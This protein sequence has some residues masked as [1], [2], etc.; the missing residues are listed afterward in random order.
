M[1]H[2]IFDNVLYIAPHYKY[3]KGGISAVITEY[4]RSIKNFHYLPS[5]TSSNIFL[6]ALSFPFIILI[7]SFRLLVSKKI[8]IV[9]IHGASKGSFYRKFVFFLIAKKFFSKKVVYHIHGAGYHLFYG[10]ASPFIKKRVRRIIN[11]SDCLIVLSA[12]WKDFFENEFNPPHI[13]IVPNIVA[14]PSKIVLNSKPYLDEFNTQEKIINLLFLGRI[15]DRKGIFDLLK[16]LTDN[17]S[18]FETRCRLRVGGDGEVDKLLEYIKIHNLTEI[19]EYIGFVQ[20]E[21]KNLILRE[22]DIYVLPSYNE[23]LPI[24][25]LEAMSYAKPIISTTVGGIPEIVHDRY[26]G[27]LFEPGNLE[28][29]KTALIELIDDSNLLETYGK[30][31]YELVKDKHFP[32]SVKEILLEL[33]DELI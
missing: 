14:K 19:V 23:G 1:K 7:F 22:S 8:K 29:L 15:G 17:K 12:W 32:D 10:S 31:S 27:T 3:W 11:Q 9:H 2:D 18:F 21:K 4:K 26:N 28:E 5:T 6:T 13:K 33:Y 20:G 24:S 25:I 16:V 30:N